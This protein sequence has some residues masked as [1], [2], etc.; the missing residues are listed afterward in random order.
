MEGGGN[1]RPCGVRGR[2][3]APSIRRRLAGPLLVL[4][5]LLACARDPAERLPQGTLWAGDA[6]Q[7]RRLLAG[8]AGLQGT[9]LGLTAA[10]LGRRLAGCRR[11]VAFCPGSGRCTIASALRCEPRDRLAALADEV[12]GKAGWVFVVRRPDRSL[13]ALGETRPAGDVSVHATLRIEPGDELWQTLLPARGAADPPVLADVGTLLHLRLRSDHGAAT[14]GKLGRGGW[15]EQLFGLREKLFLAMD[16]EGTVELAVFEPAPAELIPPM[17]LAIHVRRSGPATEAM[18]KLIADVRA[19]WGVSR[20]SWRVGAAEGAC[21]DD[22]NV[23]PELAPCY[24]ATD[25]ALVVGWNPRSVARALAAPPAEPLSKTSQIVVAL[26][27][28]PAA[29]RLLRASYDSTGGAESRWGWSRAT[30]SGARRWSAYVLDL[31]LRAA[32]TGSGAG[33]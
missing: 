3:W 30:L 17:A 23:L 8:L 12:R 33:R 31:E 20:R 13:T 27:R 7:A 14:L 25:R 15:S 29:D 24:V 19:R 6:A 22:L 16:L 2:R 1:G 21:L 9:P 4:S 32:N 10:D 5:V 26:D 11:F 28:F 18:E